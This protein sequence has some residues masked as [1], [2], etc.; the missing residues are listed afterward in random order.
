MGDDHESVGRLIVH[1]NMAILISEKWRHVRA[2]L[3]GHWFSLAEGRR[4]GRRSRQKAGS[5]D[6]HDRES[7]AM[8]S[9]VTSSLKTSR[10]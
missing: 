1:G 8:I 2:H 4:V 3:K 7:P 10:R 5:L 9:S 6:Q